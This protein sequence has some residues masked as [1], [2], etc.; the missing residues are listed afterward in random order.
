M[1]RQPLLPVLPVV[2]LMLVLAGC[3]SPVLQPFQSSGGLVI[4]QE[5]FTRQI[6]IAINIKTVEIQHEGGNLTV[7]GWDQPYMLVE[8]AKQ[9]AAETVEEAQALLHSID[10]SAY[11]SP[12]NRMVIEYQD[13][14][15]FSWLKKPAG[16]IDYTAKVPRGITLELKVK[17]GSVTVS[18]VESDV[19]ITHETGD[20]T[21][22]RIRANL[23][24]RSTGNTSA[25][26]QVRVRDVSS[27]VK[28]ETKGT[29]L[30]VEQIGGNADI[31]HQNGECRARR[32]E[33]DVTF[34]GNG[35]IL[36]LQEVKGYINLDN[37]RGD[38]TCELFYDGI[39]AGVTNGSLRLEPQAPIT[40]GIEC[41]VDTGNLVLRIPESASIMV[42]IQAV[43]GSIHSDFPMPVRAEGNVSYANGSINSGATRVRLEVRRGIASLLKTNPV[44]PVTPASTAVVPS[45]SVPPAP[46]IPASDLNPM[47]SPRPRGGTGIKDETEI[48]PNKLP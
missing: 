12:I 16:R 32:I 2:W 35:A 17:N 15:G 3:N 37:R 34:Q 13:S 23:D 19:W 46:L 36:T 20:V 5:P 38:V 14:Q 1:K 31:T 30:E 22:E 43:D 48:K 25:G 24:I 11:E 33:R 29:R 40:R 21:A 47:E 42:E 28:L 41:N 4:D 39:R 8:G 45:N 6:Q 10:I 27:N 44:L 9:A 7:M 26:N 18:D